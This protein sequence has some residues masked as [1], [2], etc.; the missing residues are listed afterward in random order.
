M[1]SIRRIHADWN[2]IDGTRASLS[3]PTGGAARSE[4]A[5]RAR[6]PR[7]RASCI[8]ILCS[9]EFPHPRFESAPLRF[10]SR[11]SDERT[12]ERTNGPTARSLESRERRAV[13]GSPQCALRDITARSCVR[14]AIIK[15]VYYCAHSLTL[16]LIFNNLEN[17]FFFFSK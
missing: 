5:T 13:N 2:T 12:N 4:A 6:K 11:V 7:R 3:R 10:A 14:H 16:I 9:A 17:K 15:F 8:H 1:R